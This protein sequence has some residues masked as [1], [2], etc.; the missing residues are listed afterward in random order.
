MFHNIPIAR[1]IHK[2]ESLTPYTSDHNQNESKGGIRIL[3]QEH[4]TAT[5]HTNA[6]KKAQQQNNRVSTQEMC[7]NLSRTLWRHGRGVSKLQCPQSMLDVL[8]HAT[9]GPFYSPKGA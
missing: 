8:L 4:N 6:K 9:R 3:T 7:S 1:N 2:L 5:T